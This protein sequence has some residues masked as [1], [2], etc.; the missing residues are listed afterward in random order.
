M[1]FDARS[2]CISFIGELDF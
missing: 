2:T 1:G